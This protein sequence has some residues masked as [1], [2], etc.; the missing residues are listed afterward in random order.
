MTYLSDDILT[1]PDTMNA[2][3][4][5]WCKSHDW[6]THACI[7]DGVLYVMEGNITSS[8]TNEQALYAWAGY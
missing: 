8:F 4:V 7:Q 1:Y 2:S 3:H 5:A 6:C